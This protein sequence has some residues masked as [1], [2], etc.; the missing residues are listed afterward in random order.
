MVQ[1]EPM[2]SFASHYN[3]QAMRMAEIPRQSMAGMEH[4]FACGHS[5]NLQY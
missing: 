5:V 3:E 2:T 4:N 1:G